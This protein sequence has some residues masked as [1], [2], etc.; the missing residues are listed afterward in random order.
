MDSLRSRDALHQP[1]LCYVTDR[2]AL[3]GA[4]SQSIIE[5]IRVA[6]DAR[7]DWIQI[8]EKDLSA[9]ELFILSRE[10]IRVAEAAGG[11]TRVLVNDRLDV[12]VAVDADGVHL[13]RE[14]VS[15]SDVARWCRSGNA[16]PGFLIGVS[17]HRIE[18]A[19]EVEQAGASYIFFGPVY[20]TPSKRSFG[21][22][23]GI[24]RFAS[25]CGAVQ[26]PVIAIG[27]MNQENAEGAVKAGAAGIAAIRLVQES[28]DAASLKRII[29]RL[30]R[31]PRE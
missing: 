7:V 2:K 28:K 31:I 30:H 18:E 20:D 12:A 15:V 25:V 27:G 21:S 8:R 6:V 9:R 24:A 19:L 1:T 17:C 3:S 4:G 22:P 14:S 26:L 13:G 11:Y 10:A 16:P 29:E 23:Q 5:R